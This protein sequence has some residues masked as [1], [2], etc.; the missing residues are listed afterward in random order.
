MRDDTALPKKFAFIAA[1]LLRTQQWYAS[2]RFSYAKTSRMAIVRKTAL[3]LRGFSLTI[4]ISLTSDIYRNDRC[5][6]KQVTLFP[7]EMWNV[8][9]R[10]LKMDVLAH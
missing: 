3:F 1:A 7:L 2:L 4:E 9:S 8:N 6:S 10:P 5:R